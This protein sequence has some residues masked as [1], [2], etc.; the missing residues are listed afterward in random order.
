MSGS[1]F[2]FCIAAT[3]KQKRMCFR[4][5][6]E[7]YVEEFG[8]EP[9]NSLRIETDQYDQHSLHVL[10][11]DSAGKA[12]G[13][14]RVIKPS[15][16]GL[17]VQH[18]PCRLEYPDG[19]QPLPNDLS[20]EFSRV[21]V[22]QKYRRGNERKA[23]GVATQSNDSE[24]MK[25]A[26]EL[27][28]GLLTKVVWTALALGNRWFYLVTDV[29]VV[30]VC[31][32]YGFGAALIPL[33][34]E[35]NYHGRRTAYVAGLQEVVDATNEFNPA[36][37]TYVKSRERTDVEEAKR[38]ARWDSSFLEQAREV[39]IRNVM[40]PQDWATFMSPKTAPFPSIPPWV[41]PT[42]AQSAVAPLMGSEKKKQMVA[43]L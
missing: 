34:P 43:H 1:P 24:A 14:A 18:I 20:V 37:H 38:I 5:R 16:L 3:K 7:V 33:G 17:P 26:P 9:P 15:P 25:D 28:L 13:T 8:F 29:K 42:S 41:V 6:Y 40:Q 19:V 39:L 35:V 12:V 4:L 30:R 23:Y 32:Y 21:T 10:A 22:A 27:M 36:V 2:H 11:T 31:Q